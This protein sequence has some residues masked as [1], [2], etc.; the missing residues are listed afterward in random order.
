MTSRIL[1]A[2]VL[3]VPGLAAAQGVS[4]VPL[5]GG[6][7]GLHDISV[8]G[9]TPGG[10]FGLVSANAAGPGLTVPGCGFN[11]D[12]GP[13]GIVVRVTRAADASGHFQLDVDIPTLACGLVV[14]A[15]DLDACAS[16]NVSDFR[17]D[18]LDCACGGRVSEGDVVWA[19][20]D[21]PAGAS[22]ISAG[23]RGVVVAGN[24]GVGGLEVLVQWDDWTSGHDGNCAVADCGECQP[25]TEANRWY[26]ACADVGLDGVAD[27]FDAWDESIWESLPPGFEYIRG[28]LQVTGDGAAMRSLDTW[29]VRGISS[30]L[31]KDESCDDHFI[32][33]S[34]DPAMSWSWA[35]SPGNMKFVWNCDNKY[36]YGPT[37]S[38]YTACADLAMYDIDINISGD[39]ATF[40]TS[41]FCDDV[42]LTDPLLSSGPLYVYIGADNDEGAA[43]W[44]RIEIR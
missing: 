37:S 19:A 20:V 29:S 26:V 40:S 34:E 17:N 28:T 31:D 3:I 9:L 38:A 30:T 44:D 21:A 43:A 35:S 11:T 18:V 15:I 24:T 25:S 16:S 39:T 8:T 4:V 14:Q 6:C 1:L 42:E 13:A 41:P 2:A 7:P 33:L 12:I 22:G 36:I 32:V 23:D 5:E 27:E 10:N